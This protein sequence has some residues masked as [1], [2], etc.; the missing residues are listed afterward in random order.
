MDIYDEIIEDINLEEKARI[1]YTAD[2]YEVYVNTDDSGGIPHFHYRNSTNEFHTCIRMDKAEYFYHT[3]KEPVLT[4]K[5]RK[6]LV[7]FLTAKPS[8]TKSYNT[9][10]DFVKDMW[11]VNNSNI[12]V[13]LNLEMPDYINLK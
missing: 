8:K 7:K 2:S 10:W 9:N 4:S 11:N 6:E 13:N 5:Q 3:G 1:G 12:E